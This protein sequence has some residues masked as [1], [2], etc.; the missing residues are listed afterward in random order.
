MRDDLPEQVVTHGSRRT[1]FVRRLRNAG[2]GGTFGSTRAKV[3][4][5]P[6]ITLPGGTTSAHLGGYLSVPTSAG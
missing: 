6:E 2:K 3:A 1:A 4:C 5:M